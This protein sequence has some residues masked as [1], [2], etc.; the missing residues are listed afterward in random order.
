MSHHDRRERGQILPLFALFLIVLLA[1]AALAIDVSN[2]YASRRFY[3][4]VADAAALAGAQDLQTSSRQVTPADQ[5]TARQDVFKVLQDRLGG[6]VPAAG[7]CNGGVNDFSTDLSGCPLPGTAFVVSI[8]TPSPTCVACDR[9]HSVQVTVDNPKFGLTF[10]RVVGVA[11]WNVGATSVAG[12]AFSPKYALV[13]LQPPNIKNNGT[14][15]NLNKDLIANGQ[16]TLVNIT[17]GDVGTNTSATTTNMGY[18]QLAS[19]YFI[20]HYDDLSVIGPTWTQVNGSPEGRPISSLILDPNYMYPTFPNC[21]VDATHCYSTQS[22]GVVPCSGANF[23]TDR[24]TMFPSATTTCY[25][26]GVYA[27]SQP[28]TVGSS[29]IAYLMPGAYLFKSGLSVQGL[30]GGGLISNQEGVVLYLPESG[31][32]TLAANNAVDL[33]L[34]MGGASCTSDGCRASPAIDWAG[35][36]V[37]TPDG[38]LLTIEVA[39]DPSCFSGTTPVVCATSSNR[40]VNLPGNGN[41]ALAGVI[42]GPSDNMS[43]NGNNTTQTGTVGQIVSY[44][45]TYTGGAHLNQAFP[46]GLQVGVV[47]LDAACTAPSTPCNNP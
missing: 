41:V 21:S 26:A 12:L 20:D 7:T 8:K 27:D 43:I 24:P 36:P 10:S 22:A 25:Q 2:A 15:A 42:Y 23:P 29:Q 44:T 31:T 33:V 16:N 11:T 13:T 5:Q 6:S 39:R 19:D 35:Q 32:K 38:L 18:I 14:D 30:L 17:I 3:R 1:F 37:K 47:R 45:T 4:A 34:N 40:T 46:G 9:A 28:F